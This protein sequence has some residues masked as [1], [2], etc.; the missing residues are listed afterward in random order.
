MKIS[1]KHLL[2]ILL[3][4]SVSTISFAQCNINAMAVYASIPHQDTLTV[5]VGSTIDLISQGTCATIF[6]DNFN[7]QYLDSNWASTAANPVFDNPCQCPF[8]GGQPPNA[9]NYG[10]PGQAGPDGAFVWI[11]ATY[12]QERILTTRAFNL[13]P[14]TNTGGCKIKW[15]MMYGITPLDGS[16]EDP[17]AFDEG[18]HMQY[19]VNNGNTWTDFSG[20]NSNPVGNLSPTPPFNTITPGNGGYWTPNGTLSQQLQSTNYFWNAYQNNL[21]NIS[22]TANTKFRWAQL[23]TSS[24]GYDSWGIDEVSITCNDINS[25]VYWTHNNSIIANTFN[26]QLTPT[27]SGWYYVTIKDTTAVPAIFATDSVYI[28]IQNQINGPINVC[29]GQSNIWYNVN[30]QPNGANYV[31]TL[32]QGFT[33]NSALNTIVINVGQNAQSGIILLQIFDNQNNL[34]TTKT[35]QVNVSAT[36]PVINGSIS[37]SN[38]VCGGQNNLIYSINPVSNAVSYSWT[39]PNGASGLS[40]SNTISLNFNQNYNSGNL[41]VK[42]INACGESQPSSLLIQGTPLPQAA[43]NISGFSS[44]CSGDTKPF[45]VSSIP[46]AMFYEWRLPDGTTTS[47]SQNN[48]NMNFSNINNPVTISVKGLNFCGYGDSNSMQIN[49]LQKPDSAT[50]IIGLTNLCEGSNNIVYKCSPINNATTYHWWLPYGMNGYSITDSINVNVSQNTYDG[51]IILKGENICGFG[52]E[53]HLDIVFKSAPQINIIGQNQ[54]QAFQTEFYSSTY[55]SKYIYNWTSYNGNIVSGQGTNNVNIQW[56]NNLSGLLSLSVTDTSNYCSFT[57]DYPIAIGGSLPATPSF[58]AFY[59]NICQNDSLKTY[60][61][62]NVTNTTHY[63][64]QL[65]D[66]TIDTTTT[67]SLIINFQQHMQSGFLTVK[68]CNQYGCSSVSNL[69][70]TVYPIPPTP[71]ITQLGNALVSS[72]NTGNQWFST[73]T[74]LQVYDIS[75]IFYP[76]YDR[77]YYV[78]VYNNNT[79]CYSLPSNVINYNTTGIKEK[80]EE[81]ELKIYPNPAKNELNIELNNHN[82]ISEYKIFNSTGQLMT[83]DK[84]TEKTLVNIQNYAQGMYFIIIALQDKILYKKIIKE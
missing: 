7:S 49:V 2:L 64:W 65:P 34:L 77:N 11:G 29:K 38:P 57:K 80:N 60:E 12:A 66:G 40:Y 8:V 16:C 82:K 20:S 47:T 22:Y 18:V 63:I 73:T 6:K 4:I 35:L 25:I 45:A 54:T 53:S 41:I 58:V 83:T 9:C 36:A 71:S 10:T 50:T 44:V 51:A 27:T 32:P 37:G 5:D 39:L 43:G 84:F 81:T 78:V 31:W 19:S 1:L 3:S 62:T 52:A 46:N 48:I 28:N 30:L 21:P 24:T 56:G 72:S 68:A 67:N 70:I 17:D 33:G 69:P 14:Y 75:N 55:N 74:G 61:I 23:A 15:W 42:A 59:M 79:G 26:T 76:V 13:S